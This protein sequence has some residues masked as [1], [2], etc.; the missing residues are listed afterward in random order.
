MDAPTLTHRSFLDVTQLARPGY[1]SENV[2]TGRV[3][4][5]DQ[6]IK[7]SMQ[8]YLRSTWQLLDL[9]PKPGQ[10][11]KSFATDWEQR[12]SLLLIDSGRVGLYPVVGDRS[13]HGHLVI[14]H[15]GSVS[16]EHIIVEI[17]N[18]PDYTELKSYVERGGQ[19][20]VTSMLYAK[21]KPEA[22]L[23]D[24]ADLSNIYAALAKLH[25]LSGQ[26]EAAST[27]EARRSDL[28]RNWERKLPNNPYVRRQI[29]AAR[30][31]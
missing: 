13:P 5:P 27:L 17:A 25:H 1:T 4:N 28:W 14:G 18:R 11:F 12:C 20:F 9:Y 29:E 19:A 10:D 21:P 3:D 2:F 24:A 26:R 15:R 16:A 8:G 7:G 22:D 6:P 31:Q 30:V 23:A